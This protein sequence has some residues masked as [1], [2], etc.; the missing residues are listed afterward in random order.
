MKADKWL[1]PNFGCKVGQNVQIAIKLELG[2]WHHPIDVYAKFQTD[3][4]KHVQKSPANFSLAESS[5][6]NPFK[7]FCPSEGPT[8]TKIT[9]DQ[10]THNINV[11][12]KSEASI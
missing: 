1:W 4:S 3:I 5:S 10:D 11:Y 6:N 8:M 7:C 9:R 12:T 2:V